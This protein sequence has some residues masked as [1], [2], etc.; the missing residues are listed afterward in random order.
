VR[1]SSTSMATDPCPLSRLPGGSCRRA[2]GVPSTWRRTKLIPHDERCQPI[3]MM[4]YDE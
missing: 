3:L 2:A 1:C 4:N